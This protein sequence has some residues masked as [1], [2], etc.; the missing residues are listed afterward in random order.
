MAKKIGYWVAVFFG[1]VSAVVFIRLVVIAVAKIG[2]YNGV[3]MA[4][5]LVG[6]LALCLLFWFFAIRVGR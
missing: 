3:I 6:S 2:T 4:C 5:L 1:L